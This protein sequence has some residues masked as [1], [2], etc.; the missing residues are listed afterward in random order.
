MTE[1]RDGIPEG[2]GECRR[3]ATAWWVTEEVFRKIFEVRGACPDH[4]RGSGRTMTREEV[5]VWL[6]MRS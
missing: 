3:K 5:E 1:V 2:C 4:A 6:V